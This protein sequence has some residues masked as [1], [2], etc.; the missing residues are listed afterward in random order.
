LG[1]GWDRYFAQAYPTPVRLAIAVGVLVPWNECNEKH[2]ITINI[3]DA[4]G[5]NVVPEV[6]AQVEVGRPTG[7]LP[8]TS[9]RAML[10]I[11]TM[12]QLL[13]PGRFE[14][15]IAGSDDESKRIAFDAVLG[16][17]PQK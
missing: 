2:P 9:Q 13:K 1:G 5:K 15:L 7:I 11:N 6:Q 12:F 8:G 14:V 17:K 16:T 10:A 3:V 4:D